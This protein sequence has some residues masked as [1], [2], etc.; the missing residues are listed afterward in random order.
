VEKAPER[1]D[2][3][4][5]AAFRELGLQLRKRDVLLVLDLPEDE[6]GLRFDPGGSA[7][8]ALLLRGEITGG[9]GLRGPANG[10]RCAHLEML[11]RLAP[12]QAPRDRLDHA[13]PQVH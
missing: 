3:E 10:A 1:A 11:G 12:R 5:H 13:L 8:S 2:A 9:L 7:I 4:P 6:V